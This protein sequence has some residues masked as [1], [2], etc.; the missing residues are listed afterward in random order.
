MAWVETAKGIALPPPLLGSGNI[1]IS[2]LVDGGRNGNGNF[3]GQVV[4]DDKL[5]LEMSFPALSPAE[6]MGLLK[7]FDRKRGGECR[8]TFR[9]FDP[10]GNDFVYMDMYVGDR[11]GT[12]YLVNPQTM[13]PSFWRDVKAN[14]IQV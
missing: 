11:S 3:I 14:L 4:G 7:I 13:R 2:T 1:S 8:N 10:R 6:F 12:P 9:V 5:K